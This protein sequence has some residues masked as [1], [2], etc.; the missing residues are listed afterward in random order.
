LIDGS[1]APVPAGPVAHAGNAP[2]E[3]LGVDDMITVVWTEEWINHA[4]RMREELEA[5]LDEARAASRR[6]WWR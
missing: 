3:G 4:V 6:A 2:L 5:G 1:V